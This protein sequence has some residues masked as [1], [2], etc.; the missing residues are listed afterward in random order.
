M[1]GLD[2]DLVYQPNT[3]MVFG[4]AKKVIESMEV[5]DHPTNSSVLTLAIRN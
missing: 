1:P 5:L 3:M 4:D 2:N